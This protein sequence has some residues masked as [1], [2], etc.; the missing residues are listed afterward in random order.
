[1]S[2]L[3]LAFA[4]LT[5]AAAQAADPAATSLLHQAL[6]AQ[7]GE[8]RLRAV[9]ALRWTAVGYRNMLEQSERPEGPYIVEYQTLSEIHDQK[10]GR[11]RSVTDSAIYPVARYSSGYV[12]DGTAAMRLAGEVR[13]PGSPEMITLSR[14]TLALSPE[15]LLLTALDSADAHLEAAAVL[16]STPQDVIGFSLDGAPV[17]IYLNRYTH[18]PT[19][20]DY[21]GPLARSGYWRFLGDVTMR[22]SYG[23]WW[24]AKGGIRL[25]MQWDVARNGLPDASY[26]IR[27]LSLDTPVPETDL[28]IAPEI[29]TAFAAQPAP[30]GLGDMPFGTPRQPAVDLAPGIVLVPGSWNVTFV[31]QDDGVV[32]IEAPISSGYTAKSIAEA[33]RRFPGVPIKAVITTSDS[34][35]HVAG[36]R[37]YVAQ[38]IAIYHLDINAPILKRV[39][40]APYT[41]RPDALERSGRARP[42]ILKPV[43]GAT[44]FG[45]GPNRMMIY[46]IRGETS[47]RQLMVYFP[48]HRLL[49]GSDPFQRGA[50]GSLSFPQAVTELADAAAREG[51]NPDRFFMMHI[52]PTPWADLTK[53]VAEAGARDTPDGKY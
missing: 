31:R 25:P 1:M 11:L 29:R 40:G 33:R 7:G 52:G 41:S 3:L 20:M 39:I 6:A 23:F 48:E 10:G 2:Y 49:Y 45:S 22:T 30:V 43:S 53:A 38:G 19:A 35:P 36:I 50:D 9:G 5:A 47:E 46:P 8:A 28:A 13:R 26:S 32:I 16:Q 17:R 4:A 15:R 37:E 12:T 44:A 24:I 51:L 42:A 34:W 21:A 14:E 27:E 18:L